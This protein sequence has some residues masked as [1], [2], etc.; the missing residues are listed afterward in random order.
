MFKIVI[1]TSS[2]FIFF[3]CFGVSVQAADLFFYSESN[4]IKTGK[5]FELDVLFNSPDDMINALEGELY[6]P[7]N[8]LS[9]IDIR[10]NNSI[11]N[12]WL[13]KPVVSANKIKFS[14]IIPG[15]YQGQGNLFKVIFRADNSGKGQIAASDVRILLNDGYGTDVAV[16][17][18]PFDIDISEETVS[19]EDILVVDISDQYPPEPFTPIITKISDIGGDNYL[20]IFATQDKSSGIDY[21]QIK[22]G[23]SPFIDATSPYILRNQSLDKK[24]IIKAVD[25]SGNIRQVS[26]APV[27]LNHWYENFVFFAIIVAVA[28]LLIVGRIRWKK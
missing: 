11:I 20:L 16:S 14:G 5:F 1:I 27:Y 21:Y 4:T 9:V 8:L 26:I 17:I 7:Q 25:K 15:G 18:E 6:F 19:P 13:E 3:V 23:Y 10:E 22:E 12:F 28:G 2:L 24:I